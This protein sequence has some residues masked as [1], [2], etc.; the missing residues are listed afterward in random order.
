[1]NESITVPD[2]LSLEPASRE[3]LRAE[4]P[5]RFL[6]D[7]SIGSIKRKAP[8]IADDAYSAL[9]Q[10]MK[11]LRLSTDEHGALSEHL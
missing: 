9:S 4:E 10:G 3:A 7:A 5:H 6:G 8:Y 1:M 11:N 2:I